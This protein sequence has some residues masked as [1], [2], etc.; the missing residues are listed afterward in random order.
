M[1]ILTNREHLLPA[2]MRGAG[3]V[4]RRQTLPILGNFYLNA[5]E[6]GAVE[7]VG[8]D[9]EL[10]IRTSFSATVNVPGSITLPARK[11]TDIIR[12]LPEGAD[13]RI[14]V[15]GDKAVLSSG[16]GRYTLSTLPADGYPLMQPEVDG[17]CMELDQTQLRKVLEKTAFAMAQHDVRYYLNGLL[18]EVRPGGLTAVATDGHRLAKVELDLESDLSE[19]MQVILPGKTVAELKRLLLGGDEKVRINLTERTIQLQLGT[20]QVTSKLIDGRY[21]EYDRVIPRNPD[22]L[23]VVDRGALRQA[24]QRTSVLSNEKYKGVRLTFDAGLLR[25]QAHNPEQDEAEEEL[26]LDYKSEPT[27]IGFNVAYVMDLL[28]VLE[29]DEVEISFSDGNSSALWR[30]KGVE[31]ETYVVM[32]MRL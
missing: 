20:T 6:S 27:T 31:Q 22:R 30:N 12:A 16:R 19:P 8:T 13:I 10:E 11:I 24:L 28:G 5:G 32:P 26:E 21:P 17:I 1:Q 25:L 18:L 2:L 15:D 29:K 4:E 23:A 3:V 14:K 7:L 9:L